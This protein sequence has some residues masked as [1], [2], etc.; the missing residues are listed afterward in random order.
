M[1]LFLL[2]SVIYRNEHIVVFDEADGHHRLKEA[3]DG[4]RQ[5][6]KR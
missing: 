3:C 2:I 5:S 6:V 1:V 4:Q